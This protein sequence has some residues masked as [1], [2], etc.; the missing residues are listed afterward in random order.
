MK[1]LYIENHIDITIASA[2][3]IFL[4]TLTETYCARYT[5][6]M[7]PRALDTLTGIMRYETKYNQVYVTIIGILIY[8][9]RAICTFLTI[10]S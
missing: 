6:L 9:A 7:T 5:S 8:D 3:N 1:L 4:D 10:M 2:Y